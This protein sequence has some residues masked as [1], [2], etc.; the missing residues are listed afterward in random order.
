M[1]SGM[2]AVRSISA[3]GSR[4]AEPN[5]DTI[6]RR[7]SH[8]NLDRQSVGSMSLTLLQFH[9][10]WG[11]FQWLEELMKYCCFLKYPS[12]DP[13]AGSDT[14]TAAIPD[15]GTASSRRSR[16]LADRRSA[17]SS[18]FSAARRC[19]DSPSPIRKHSGWSQPAPAARDNPAHTPP[20]TPPTKPPARRVRFVVASL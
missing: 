15:A 9:G 4:M 7:N 2:G 20:L 1:T 5:S 16:A 10:I 8:R 19:S 12:A 17:S 14:S 13:C 3:S 18:H 6:S 11:Q